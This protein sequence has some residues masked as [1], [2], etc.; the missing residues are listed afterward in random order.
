ME[1]SVYQSARKNVLSNSDDGTASGSN[2][3]RP[4]K[5][6]L[7]TFGSEGSTWRAAYIKER[8]R[9]ETSDTLISSWQNA[10]KIAG[11]L[12]RPIDTVLGPCW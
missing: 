7:I 10:T 8:G 2:L 5:A 3:L 4:L 1:R 12:I 6:L 11:W 9:N